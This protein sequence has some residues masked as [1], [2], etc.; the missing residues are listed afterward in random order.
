MEGKSEKI[1]YDFCKK[2][3]FSRIVGF[4]DFFVNC[5]NNLYRDSPSSFFMILC[6]F[7]VNKILECQFDQ[8]QMIFLLVEKML[9]N[10]DYIISNEVAV[11]FL[12]SLQN[13]SSN[14]TFSFRSIIS[15][16]GKES[17]N[18]CK[19][20]DKYWGVATDGLWDDECFIRN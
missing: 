4:E 2:V 8:L 3:F 16:L 6:D 15:F 17:L 11:S 13:I 14:G 7:V 10:G 12:E 9:V 19:E 1:D 20:T 5:I 18:F